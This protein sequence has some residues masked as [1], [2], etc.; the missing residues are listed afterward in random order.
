MTILIVAEDTAL[1]ST[2]AKF[3]WKKGYETVLAGDGSQAFEA[4]VQSQVRIAVSAAS[5]TDK[6]GLALCHALR[7]RPRAGYLYFIQLTETIE[8]EERLK[9]FR[10]G[11]DAYLT[12]PVDLDEFEVQILVGLRVTGFAGLSETPGSVL[13]KTEAPLLVPGADTAKENGIKKQDISDYDI[14]LARVALEEKLVTKEQLAQAFSFQKRESRTRGNLPLADIF[15]ETRMVP[16]DRLETLRAATKE[17]LEKK[18]GFFAQ[19]KGFATKAQVDR[20]LAEQA[21]EFKARQSCRLTGDILVAHGVITPAQREA[22]RLEMKGLKTGIDPIPRGRREK[23]KQQTVFEE[24]LFRIL[25]SED[26]LEAA[27]QVRKAGFGTIT[28]DP[29]QSALNKLG[30]RSGG[31]P[32]DAVAAFLNSNLCE[33][34][35]FAIAKGKPP[36][37]GQDAIVVYHFDTDHLKAGTVQADGTIN[38]M[39]RGIT[40]RVRAGDLLAVKTPMQ[41]G[42]AGLDIYGQPIPVPDA[43]DMNF[44][45]GQGAC[46]SEGGETVHAAIDG[47]PSLAVDGTLFVYAEMSIDGDVSFKTGNIDFDGNVN[48]NGTIMSGFTVK[49]GNLF[50]KEIVGGKIFARGDVTVP[51]GIIGTDIKSE[52][53]VTAKFITDSNIKCFGNVRVDKEVIHSKIRSSGKFISERCRVIASFVSAKMGFESKEVGTDVSKPC[54]INVGLDENVKK[55][56]QALNYAMDAPKKELEIV[57]KRY[58][59]RLKK[60]QLI[61]KNL[62]ESARS[63]KDRA[64]LFQTQEILEEKI[65]QDLAAIEMLIKEVEA[66]SQE[67]QAII[68]WSQDEKGVPVIKVRG[69]IQQGTTLYGMHASL[70]LRQT[71]KNVTIAEVQP[72]EGDFWQMTI[73]E[74]K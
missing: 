13:P 50:A 34:A 23:E 65:A 56:I 70:T 42:R 7:N 68:K 55:R 14:L 57:Q 51:G 21:E 35:S 54:R 4:A 20:A 52:G 48:V 71:V 66:V 1:R 24:P 40:P 18:F 32:M 12:Q 15:I 46:L 53:S 5:I 9:G 8:K 43:V 27:V 37:M 67:K 33:T 17:R 60:Q 28:S 19:K 2:L 72:S 47:Q 49:C 38:Y 73:V 45:C 25:V 11:V 22:V 39:E 44:K 61:H 26:R 10:Q 64:P 36:V 63:D 59:N 30:I 6:E 62:A 29:I 69:Q 16:P 74:S 58:E 3:L 31:V 41:E